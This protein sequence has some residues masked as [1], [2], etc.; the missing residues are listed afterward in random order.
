MSANTIMRMSGLDAQDLPDSVLNSS[1][2]LL[3][4][5]LCQEWPLVK[6]GLE[7]NQAAAEL[8]QG[9]AANNPVH[10]CYGEPDIDGRIFYNQDVSGFNFK[11]ANMPLKAVLDRMLAV[12][13]EPNPP[14]VYI[15][16]TEVNNWFPGVLDRHGCNIPG[17]QPLTSLW[18]GNKTR[19]AAHYD[20]PTN[21]ACNLVGKRRFTLFPPS[22]IANLYVGPRNH[23]PGGQ[24]ISMVDFANPDLERLPK[25]KVA[26]E[27]AIV[28][29]LQPGD[30]LLLPSMWWHHVEA[31][32][33]FN[34]LMSHWWR[35]SPGF[36]GRPDNALDAAILAIR[37]L[38]KAQRLAW[39][40]I[41]DHYV[42]DEELDPLEQIP[43]QVKAELTLPLDEM[44]ARKLRADLQNKLKR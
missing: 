35:N 4:E 11:G 30:A 18:I 36:Y 21:I 16:S 12:A 33:S 40:H 15:P 14:T 13:N 8:L 39:K 1:E 7:S 9:Y 22:Q 2:P 26:L 6:A 34:V 28:V 41:F 17:T 31:Q 25:F 23:A 32:S 37:S 27:H 42:F 29:E 3:L 24:P 38:P 20:F 19:I 44:S 10:A 43:D 5:G